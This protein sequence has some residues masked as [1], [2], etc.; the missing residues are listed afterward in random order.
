MTVA[1]ACLR[2]GTSIRKLLLPCG[3]TAKWQL[4]SFIRA[5]RGRGRKIDELHLIHHRLGSGAVPCL[6]SFL[7]EGPFVLKKLCMCYNFIHEVDSET[8]FAALEETGGLEE[9]H[10]TH[11]TIGERGALA[12]ARSLP[13]IKNLRCLT[14]TWDSKM[15]S[16]IP[17]LL[18]GFRQN[19]SLTNVN[20]EGKPPRGQWRRTIDY[21]CDRNRFLP[22]LETPQDE[23][24]AYQPSLAFWP[25]GL[26]WLSQ[27]NK[28]DAMYHVLRSKLPSLL[29]ESWEANPLKRRHEKSHG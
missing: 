16:T 18:D 26:S 9:P 19:R 12:L 6:V 8:L 11:N 25:H 23:N 7:R 13:N 21:Y 15:D 24:D 28:E 2:P 10:F 29:S 3:Q 22:L 17:A 14:I 20:I 27:V 5:W 1:N 4:R